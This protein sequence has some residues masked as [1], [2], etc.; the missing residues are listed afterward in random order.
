MDFKY[1]VIGCGIMGSAAAMHLAAASKAIALIGPSEALADE[2]AAIPKAS[3]HDQGRITRLLDA[4]VQ[5]QRVQPECCVERAI[6]R[7]IEVGLHHIA[8]V[9]GW[10]GNRG[11]QVARLE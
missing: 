2:D 9:V 5:F 8:C 7:R 6:I 11:H 4:D 1:I 10:I 3:H